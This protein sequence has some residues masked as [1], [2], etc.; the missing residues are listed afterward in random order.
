MSFSLAQTRIASVSTR[1]PRGICVAIG[2]LPPLLGHFDKRNCFNA[3][4][5]R[6][7][8]RRCRGRLADGASLAQTQA[9]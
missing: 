5:L 6:R 9:I 2:P 1:E 3:D 4:Y 7:R 8:R